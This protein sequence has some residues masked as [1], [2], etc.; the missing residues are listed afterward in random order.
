MYRQQVIVWE[1]DRFGKLVV[2]EEAA[3]RWYKLPSGRLYRVR[4]VKCKCDC[5]NEVVVELGSLR[6]EHTSSCG[7]GR[8]EK[9][10][11]HGLTEHKLYRIW[12]EMKAR[13]CNPK[14]QFFHRYGG[15][16]ITV[17][18]EWIDDFKAFHDW[19]MDNGYREGLQIDRI[20]NNKGYFPDNCRFVTC[21]ENANNKET[22]LMLV[23]D[24]ITASLADHCRR[25]RLKYKTVR[26][27]IKR[28]NW[29]AERA[30][31][32]PT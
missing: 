32:T 10:T 7:C 30:L 26:T 25:L 28:L 5:G 18:E 1:G 12:A 16:G 20:D 22:N 9:I 13:C 15:R 14:Q 19:A 3:S 21:Q 31:S 8:L 23:F 17:C 29:S 27:R 2:I 24:N 6:S 11:T 4:V